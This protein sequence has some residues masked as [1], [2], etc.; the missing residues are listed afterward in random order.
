MPRVETH[1]WIP[2]PPILGGL[3]LVGG[4]AVP[5]MG[6]EKK[7]CRVEK[8]RHIWLR[9]M[10]VGAVLVVLGRMLGVCNTEL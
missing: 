7:S 3:A 10:S 4:A 2:L 6:G 8:W 5:A 1:E 9:M